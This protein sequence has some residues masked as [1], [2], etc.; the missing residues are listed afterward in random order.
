MPFVGVVTNAVKLRCLL[1]YTFTPLYTKTQQVRQIEVEKAP[2]SSS[3]T[4]MSPYF[5]T[6]SAIPSLDD[7][8]PNSLK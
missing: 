4:F 1:H 5:L 6:A 7:F 3:R 2:M 8:S